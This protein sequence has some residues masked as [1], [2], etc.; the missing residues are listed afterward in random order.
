MTWSRGSRAAQVHGFHSDIFPVLQPRSLAFR[1]G[2]VEELG[3]DGCRTGDSGGLVGAEGVEVGRASSFHGRLRLQG[4]RQ[5]QRPPRSA[6]GTPVRRPRLQAGRRPGGPAVQRLRAPPWAAASSPLPQLL[7]LPLSS[8]LLAVDREKSPWA[9]ARYREDWLGRLLV[10]W[11]LGFED[12]NGWLGCGSGGAWWPS[13]AASATR[14]GAHGWRRRSRRLS[15][16]TASA[17]DKARKGKRARE[18]G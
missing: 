15:Y 17:R 7:L 9:A 1:R 6:H 16:P 10:G 3:G 14:G 4:E 18:G 11:R 5:L 2:G 13:A 12:A 8:S